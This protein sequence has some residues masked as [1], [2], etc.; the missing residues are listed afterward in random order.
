M[1]AKL[2]GWKRALWRYKDRST[3]AHVLSGLENGILSISSVYNAG[4]TVP[5]VE[6][7]GAE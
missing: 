4:S 1:L 2:A 6:L 3:D 5:L 7:A